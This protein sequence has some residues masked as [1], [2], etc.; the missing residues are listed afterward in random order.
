MTEDIE[1]R[2]S[3]PGAEAFT[4]PTLSA[5]Q[6]D[7]RVVDDLVVTFDATTGR[8]DDATRAAILDWVQSWCGR[9]PGA[10]VVMACN[11]KSRNTARG[12]RVDRLLT[13]AAVLNECGVHEERVRY[14][15]EVVEMDADGTP[16]VS[17]RGVVM[18]KAFR[19]AAIDSAIVPIRNL[20]GSSAANM[21]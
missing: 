20:F 19:S 15:D 14:T 5:L 21:A 7:G 1:H 9:N 2:V 17:T 16:V 11:G 6:S 12:T 3:S 4:L 8:L 13:I 18:L 10:L